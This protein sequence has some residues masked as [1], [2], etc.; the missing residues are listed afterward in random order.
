[1]GC[2]ISLYNVSTIYG[3]ITDTRQSPQGVKM[4]M[5]RDFNMDLSNMERNAREKISRQP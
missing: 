3:V 4:L 5:D 2:Y 1:M